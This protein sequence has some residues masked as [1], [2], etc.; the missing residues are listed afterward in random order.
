M[1][2]RLRERDRLYCFSMELNGWRGF[3]PICNHSSFFKTSILVHL[4]LFLVPVTLHLWR[5]LQ[6]VAPKFSTSSSF[7]AKLG[8][9]A[10][11]SF[12]RMDDSQIISI[13]HHN[14]LNNSGFFG[15]FCPFFHII[16][17]RIYLDVGKYFASMW[18]YKNKQFPKISYIIKYL[19]GCTVEWLLVTACCNI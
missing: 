13:I 10:L 9:S 2:R 5:R 16:L 3:F 6:S 15:L 17:N 19:T 11:I 1:R 8:E 7:G 12:P 4:D 14:S 18:I